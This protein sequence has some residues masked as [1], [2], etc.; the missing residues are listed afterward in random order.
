[1]RTG[2]FFIC[3]HVALPLW[4]AAPVVTS[5]GIVHSASYAALANRLPP[6]GIISI[7]GVNLARTTAQASAIPLP[8]VLPTGPQGTRVMFGDVP[9]PLFFVSSNQINLEVP[10]TLQPGSTVNLQ[11][12]SP[13]GSSAPVPVT[14]ATH[15]PGIFTADS[16]GVGL[17]VSTHVSGGLVNA[18]APATSS[19]TVVIYGTG[20][21]LGRDAVA[22]GE[23]ATGANPVR[24]P[25]LATIG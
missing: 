21:G 11:V 18:D 1:M 22:T 6:G 15:A 9:A 5:A 12:I 2:V 7:F 24:V 20:F 3:L 19:E 13:D 8:I 17:S 10:T 14:V 16:S 4:G 23:A 25:T